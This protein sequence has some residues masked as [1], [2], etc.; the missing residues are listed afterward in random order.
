M[1][2]YE[3]KGVEGVRRKEGKATAINKQ[4]TCVGET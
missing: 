4:R 3:F 2:K 1:A